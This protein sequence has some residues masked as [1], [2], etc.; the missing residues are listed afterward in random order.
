[1][2]GVIIIVLIAALFWGNYVDSVYDVFFTRFSSENLETA[3]QRTDIFKAYN[4]WLFEHDKIVSGIGILYYIDITNIGHACHSG[5][6]QIYIAYGILGLIIFLLAGGV[7]K[8]L[9]INRITF[10]YFIP[11][12]I[13]LI[14][15]QSIQFL[16]NPVLLFPFVMLAYTLRFEPSKDGIHAKTRT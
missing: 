12:V 7:Y 13:C 15:D 6:Q 14:F 4:T 3:G 16:S 9:F 1:M 10:S 8:Y 2:V 5:L 11:F